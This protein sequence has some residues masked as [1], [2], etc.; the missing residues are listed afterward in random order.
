MRTRTR[1][2]TSSIWRRTSRMCSSPVAY[3]YKLKKPLDLGF[4]DFSTLDK[5]RHY[6]EE[7]LRLNR[8]LAPDLYLAVVPITG[9]RGPSAHRCRGTGARVRTADAAVR[10]T[11]VARARADQRRAHCAHVDELAEI[12]SQFHAD[13]PPATVDSQYGTAAAIMAP[14]LQ[15]FDQLA[16]LSR[17]RCR[18]RAPGP[19]TALDSGATPQVSKAC[20]S[21]AARMVSCASATAICISRTWC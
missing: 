16:P 7:E 8:R 1:S 5:R 9:R 17:R 19:A 11:R 20:S 10:S 18:A 21:S 14:A 3:A 12:L 13:L 15:N 2:I 6:C 4:L